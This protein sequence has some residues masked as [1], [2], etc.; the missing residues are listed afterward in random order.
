MKSGLASTEIVFTGMIL[1]EVLYYH[2]LVVFE[3]NRIKSGEKW[4]SF[5][6]LMIWFTKHFLFELL[7]SS[8]DH[9]LYLQITYWDPFDGQAIR[10]LDG[11]SSEP[12]NAL[13]TDPD[14]EVVVSGGC[15]KLVKLW[16]YDEGHCYF[17]GVAHSGSITKVQVA[18]N[19]SRIVSV[20]TEGGIF[21]WEYSRPQAVDIMD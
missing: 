14:G 20:G 13:A 4:F 17:V 12:V 19:K 10:I 1:C 5:K 7:T 16:G 6:L 18:P 3:H 11:S 21:I 2:F 15:D 9:V 8:C